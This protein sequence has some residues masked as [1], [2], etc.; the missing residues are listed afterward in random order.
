[1]D[2]PQELPDIM[3]ILE[4]PALF[5]GIYAGEDPHTDEPHI[6]WVK[7]SEQ[8]EKGDRLYIVKKAKTPLVTLLEH[9]Q[10][11]SEEVAKWPEWKQHGADVT[12]FQ[13]RNNV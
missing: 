3:A 12:K 6:S 10:N 13:G 5:V 4:E 1:M 9:C 7:A 2:K 11:C 8:M